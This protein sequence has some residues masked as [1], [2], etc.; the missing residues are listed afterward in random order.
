MTYLISLSSAWSTNKIRS[1]FNGEID[2]LNDD[3]I[4][5]KFSMSLLGPFLFPLS[6]FELL[7]KNFNSLFSTKE[8]G[9]V[10]NR[11]L[12]DLIGLL[13]GPIFSFYHWHTV[14]LL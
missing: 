1:L 12:E 13:V 11:E 10:Q 5:W 8:S 4:I 7:S 3:E 6:L 2:L 14:W 9:S